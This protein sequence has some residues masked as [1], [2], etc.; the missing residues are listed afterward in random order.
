MFLNNKNNPKLTQEEI[1][2]ETKNQRK[3][4]QL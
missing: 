3:K 1:E 2:K 4:F